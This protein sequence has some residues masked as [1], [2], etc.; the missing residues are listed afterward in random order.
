M[1]QTNFFQ[2]PEDEAELLT[3]IL[4]ARGLRE[5]REV[6]VLDPTGARRPEQMGVIRAVQETPGVGPRHAHEFL[7][8]ALLGAGHEVHTTSVPSSPHGGTL[9]IDLARSPV[10]ELQRCVRVGDRLQRG[11]LYMVDDD[12]VAAGEDPESGLERCSKGEELTDWFHGIQRF[13]RASYVHTVPAGPFLVGPGAA[14]FALEGGELSECGVRYL[15]R[16]ARREG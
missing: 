14:R 1:R 12:L 6:I 3:F 10:F 13:L 4:Q 2:S 11:R 16:V 15:P 5:G 9:L 8:P 7:Y